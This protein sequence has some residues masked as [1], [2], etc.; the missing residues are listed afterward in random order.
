M[1][2]IGYVVTTKNTGT[3]KGELMHFGTFYDWE[4]R[5]FDTV[6]FPDVARN[7]PFRGKGFYEMKGMVVEDFDVITIEV[8]WMDKVAMV[9]I[10]E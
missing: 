7:Y 4:G 10:R 6:H 5:V 1:H 2:I 8:S 3:V 9:K